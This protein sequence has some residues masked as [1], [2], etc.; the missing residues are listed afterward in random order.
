[1]SRLRRIFGNEQRG[2]LVG[3]FTLQEIG[4]DVSQESGAS[5]LTSGASIERVCPEVQHLLAGVSI[6]KESGHVAAAQLIENIGSNIHLYQ[7]LKSLLRPL[8]CL[9]QT[10]LPKSAAFDV[11][12]V[13][14]RL[15]Y[16]LS[17]TLL[18]HLF[19][20]LAPIGEIVSNIKTTSRTPGGVSD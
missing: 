16:D 13:F 15:S 5:G 19:A 17:I 20:F 18:A 10:I 4:E 14:C 2:L 12:Q 8:E 1:M 11:Y 3:E 9:D 6:G 7:V